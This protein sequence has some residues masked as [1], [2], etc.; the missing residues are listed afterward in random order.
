M[1]VLVYKFDL[2]KEYCKKEVDCKGCNANNFCKWCNQACAY[3]N[4]KFNLPGLSP[5]LISNPVPTQLSNGM[6]PLNFNVSLQANC[7][8]GRIGSHR[9]HCHR[10]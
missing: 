5:S 7:S 8:T 2:A 4:S 9:N 1:I 10:W 6:C 3:D